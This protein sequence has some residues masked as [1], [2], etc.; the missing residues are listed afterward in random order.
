MLGSLDAVI[1]SSVDIRWEGNLLSVREARVRSSGYQCQ[2]PH[3]KLFLQSIPV[4]TIGQSVLQELEV[5]LVLRSVLH[6][7]LPVFRVSFTRQTFKGQFS[8]S[9]S[10]RHLIS[11][12]LLPKTTSWSQRLRVRRR[13]N[14]LIVQ[15]ISTFDQ[16]HQVIAMKYR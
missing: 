9:F 4:L 10:S 11:N 1:V 15:L 7:L 16:M 12:G 13:S 6:C 14:D 8:C 2:D 5:F 3:A